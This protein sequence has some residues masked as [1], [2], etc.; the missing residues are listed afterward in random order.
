MWRA[1]IRKLRQPRVPDKLTDYQKIFL[2]SKANGAAY[3]DP[4]LQGFPLPKG[5]WLQ[6]KRGERDV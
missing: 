6:R 3:R 2:A 5:T 4:P 1:L